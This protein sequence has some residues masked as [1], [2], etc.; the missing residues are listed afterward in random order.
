MTRAARTPD[1]VELR[2]LCAAADLGSLGRAAL[3][4]NV[5]QPALSK[6]LQSLEAAAGLQLLERSSRGVT[7]TTAG[8]RLYEQ[9]RR[10]LDEADALDALMEALAANRAPVLVA[11]SHSA[12]VAFA[13]D[14]L[15]GLQ[16]DPPFELVTANSTVVRQLV[17]DRRADVGVAPR[18]PGATPNPSVREIEL[19]PDE[20][21]YAVPRAHRWARLPEV[22]VG[23][24]AATP[25]V[26]RDAGSNARWTVEAALRERGVPH[27]PIVAEGLTPAAAMKQAVARGAP[28]L[29][30]RRVIDWEGF[31][32]VP[33]RGLR[34][35]R[36]WQAVLPAVGE[37][38]DAVR[39]LI[40]RLREAAQDQPAG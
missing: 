13:A 34:F 11:A 35:P 25:V 2:S 27:P 28:L 31:S 20:I 18:R 30:S 9:A 3:R 22:S 38:S 40:E 33:I 7:L 5:S 19:A 10:V 17:A 4:M 1:L 24:F 37:P 21:V 8:R 14:V 23:E 6:R 39:T 32:R 16:V 29:L 26:V 12:A 36:A 15:A